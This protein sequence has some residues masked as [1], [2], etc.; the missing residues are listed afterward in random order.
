MDCS[1]RDSSLDSL[2]SLLASLLPE[3]RLAVV[4]HPQ[5]GLVID[6][7]QEDKDRAGA[8]VEDTPA[9]SCP[10]VMEG[11]TEC[12]QTDTMIK[13]VTR[14]DAVPGESDGGEENGY[15]S[16]CLEDK[17]GGSSV[18]C[19]QIKELSNKDLLEKRIF[20][21]NLDGF[22]KKKDDKN[23]DT[24]GK[25]FLYPKDLKKHLLVHLKVFPFCCKL[26]K[27]GVRTISNMYKHLRQKHSITTDLKSNILDEKGEPYVE[28][29]EQIKKDVAEGKI[30]AELLTVEKV[31]EKGSVGQ[32]KNGVKLYQCL[33]CDKPVTKYSLKNHLSVHSQQPHFNCDQCDKS[34]FTN[35]ALATHKIN[36]HE[37]KICQPLKCSNCFR[38]FRSVNARD[39]HTANCLKADPQ[40]KKAAF[41]CRLCH[42]L[43]GYKNNLVSHQKT[44]HGFHGKKILNYPCKY[45]SELIKG[46]LRL[47]KHIIS[48]HPEA[49]GEL[50]DLC[51]KSFKTEIKLS[52]H[53]AVHKSRERNLH[54]SFCPKK[55]FRRD[56][57]T[58]HEKIHTSPLICVECGKKFPEQRYLDTHSLLHAEKKFDC[59]KE[60]RSNIVFLCV[61]RGSWL[62]V[63]SI[64]ASLS[65]LDVTVWSLSA[66]RA[67]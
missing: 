23:C 6:V 43:F 12:S 22:Q 19:E 45:C 37:G 46:K 52:R 26:C 48:A 29:K 62:K 18:A 36:S 24:C 41:E 27:K 8:G 60:Y 7:T 65:P 10:P 2:V 9:L 63:Y 47:S 57:L 56:V 21:V 15:L 61:C 31:M 3:L 67:S 4:S 14:E 55:F 40:R 38:T 42:R 59:H 20:G 44:A 58:V 53:T 30:D 35:S 39:H 11:Y 16:D 17:A 25:T 28:V 5:S 51:G 32:N 1:G 34:Y 50:C 33:V 64:T 54:C 66:R 49:A 13:W